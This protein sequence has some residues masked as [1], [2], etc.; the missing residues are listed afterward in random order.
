M[1]A[2]TTNTG[3]M[4]K[5]KHITLPLGQK[6]EILDKLRR[7]VSG[8]KLAQEYGIGT[9]TISDIKKNSGKIEKSVHLLEVFYFY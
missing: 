6:A 3:V 2:E 5:R 7:G 1:S 9:S 8:K 4:G